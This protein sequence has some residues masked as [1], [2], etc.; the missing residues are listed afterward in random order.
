MRASILNI[1]WGITGDIVD[2]CC[3]VVVAQTFT[4]NFTANEFIVYNMLIPLTKFVFLVAAPIGCL[5]AC[6]TLPTTMVSANGHNMDVNVLTDRFGILR[7]EL[8]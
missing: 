7:K 2:V 6:P 8:D 1:G 3:L 4:N 5:G